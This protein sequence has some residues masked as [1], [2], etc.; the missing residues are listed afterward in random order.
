M[1]H[2][3]PRSFINLV[4]GGLVVVSLPLI[5]G[6][7][8]TKIHLDKLVSQSVAL[9]EHS[10]SATHDAQQLFEYTR[11][12]E[13]N[14]RLYDI[15]GE[16]QYLEEA[17][18]WHNKIYNLLEQ[19]KQLP[20][21]QNFQ[22]LLIQFQALE[23][24]I[25]SSLQ[26]AHQNPEQQEKNIATAITTFSDLDKRALLINSAINTFMNHEL[27]K[28]KASKL[29]AQK[30]LLWQTLSFILLTVIMILI[31]AFI[32]SQPIKQINQGIDRLGRGDFSTPVFI[33]GPKDLETLGEKINWLRKRLFNLERDKTKFIAHISHDLKTPL[34]SIMEGS[35]ILQEELV[36]PLN[37]RQLAVTEILTK[38]SIKLQKLIDNI[39][40]FNMAKAGG[41]PKGHILIP[42][43]P[44]IEQVAYEQT[45]QMLSKNISL[46]LHLENVTILGDRKQLETLFDNLFSNAVKFSPKKG[47]VCCN[48]RK[49]QTEVKCI[50]SN[51]GPVIPTEEKDKIFTPFYQ[52]K[53]N[54]SSHTQGSG[55]GL[56]IVKEYVLQHNGTVS[57]L[58]HNSG[59]HFMVTFPLIIDK[60]SKKRSA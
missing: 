39:L 53:N 29:A 14:I 33:S 41:K 47:V 12:Q 55:L 9:V 59:G 46:D 7:F 10:V 4:T 49:M 58:D 32:I 43:K 38:N 28:L 52:V 57:V 22:N 60:R 31:L 56:A 48:L 50:I 21:D 19:L 51:T 1:M 2:F 18:L 35:G 3:R 23:G 42:L 24:S 20:V 45:T 17:S 40:N 34:A 27:S 37:K 25:L 5:V 16:N 13:R 54:N 15:V 36:G 30:T 6:L 44:L 26:L 11:N 8:T